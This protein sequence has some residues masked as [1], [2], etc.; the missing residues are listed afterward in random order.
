VLK[1]DPWLKKYSRDLRK[2]MTEAEMRLWDKIRQR[3]LKGRQFFRQR[4]IGSYIV[5]FYCP[6]A[7]LIIEVDGGQHYYGIGAEKDKIRDEFMN[8]LGMR[9]LRFSD[10]EVLKSTKEVLETIFE[11]L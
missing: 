11:L 3:Q 8:K 1:Y 4:P 2:N 10:L 5:D 9:V 7:K 6:T